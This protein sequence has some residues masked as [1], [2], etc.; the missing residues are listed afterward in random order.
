M[1]LWVDTDVG[2]NP[3]DAV[4]LLCAVAHPEIELVGVSTVGADAA[5]RA[6]VARQL[7]PDPIAVL[8]GA[9]AA[10][11]A[12]PAAAPNAVLAIGPLTNLAALVTM[13]GRP[14]RLVVMG[15]ALRP[16]HHRGAVRLVESNFAADPVAAGVVLAEPGVTVVPLDATVAC[17]L[18]PV[19]LEALLRAAPVLLPVV[20][21]WFAAQE[22][23]GVPEEERALYLHDPAALLVAAGEPVADLDTRSLI[24][25]GDGRLREHPDGVDHQVVV[26]LD[27]RAV[28]ARVVELLSR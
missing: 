21:V 10:V 5:W 28:V 7:V 17:R 3:D 15:G 20:E 12:I 9:A 2:T 1:R 25:E 6:E 24:L 13:A 19:D 23:A 18:E 22:K 16:V 8:A 26:D 4:A 11:G 27:G 14:A